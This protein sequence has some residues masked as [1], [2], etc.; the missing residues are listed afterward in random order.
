LVGMRSICRARGANLLLN[1]PPDRSGRIP[2]RHIDAL[3]KTRTQFE[4]LF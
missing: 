1:V 2:Q 4:K 3:M